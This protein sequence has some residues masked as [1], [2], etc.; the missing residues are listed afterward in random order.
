MVIPEEKKVV[1]RDG[2]HNT[3]GELNLLSMRLGEIE[4]KI[5]DLYQFVQQQRLPGPAELEKRLI[6]IKSTIEA[7]R[8]NKAEADKHLDKVRG[9]VD[10]IIKGD[11]G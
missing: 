6:S 10:A 1:L 2:V 5:A 8:V 11:I 7:A 3:A 4:D 9:V